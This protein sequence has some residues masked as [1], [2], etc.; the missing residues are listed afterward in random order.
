M[1]ATFTVHDP[2]TR[3]KVGSPYSNQAS[4]FRRAYKFL[5]IDKPGVFV[6]VQEWDPDYGPLRTW[7]I[8]GRAP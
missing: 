5:P 3:L 8:A 2:V 6:V 7:M 4:A 1:A